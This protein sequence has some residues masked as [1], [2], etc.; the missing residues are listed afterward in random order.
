MWSKL[1]VESGFG[2]GIGVGI[3]VRLTLTLG[4]R[5]GLQLRVWP[6]GYREA[7]VDEDPDVIVTHE[8]EVAKTIVH[9]RLL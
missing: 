4:L 6:S 8:F 2:L 1:G 5:G 7:V 9:E 3:R